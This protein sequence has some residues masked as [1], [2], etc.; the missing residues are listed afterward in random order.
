MRQ[1]KGRLKAGEMPHKHQD[2]GSDPQDPSKKLGMA[3][4]T[5]SPSVWE[6]ETDGIYQS[7]QVRGDRGG[8]HLLLDTCCYL[9]D[10]ES[11]HLLKTPQSGSEFESGSL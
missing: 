10:N 4:H 1:G 2:L 9:T 3:L 7:S 6:A 8:R 11:E 5:S